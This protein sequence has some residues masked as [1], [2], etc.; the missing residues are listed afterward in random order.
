MSDPRLN[1]AVSLIPALR[2]RERLFLADTV[3]DYDAFIRMSKNDLQALIGR[4]LRIMPEALKELSE[5]TESVLELIHARDIQMV[6]YWSSSYPPLLREI[7]DAPLLLYVRGALPEPEV[8]SV[9]IVGTRKP[10]SR[11]VAAAFSLAAEL[12]LASVA[13]V[14]GLARGIDRAA[15]EG[16]R[17]AGGT[18]IAVLGS[19]VDYIYPEHH[20]DLAERILASGGGLVSEYPPGTPPLRYHF[21]ERNRIISGICRS[22]VV[23]TAPEKSGA[24]ITADYALEQGRD[25]CVHRAGL[26][27][28]ASGLTEGTLRLEETG[29][30]V[31]EHSSDL[32]ELWGWK[33][34]AV[35][36]IECSNPGEAGDFTRLTQEELED[37]MLFYNG[38]WFSTWYAV[39]KDA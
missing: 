26:Y 38:S 14:S 32:F 3:S 34:P 9:S 36:W 19:G 20:R 24:L 21:P 25:L 18:T 28:H 33:R 8:P 30:P 35:P 6:D 39:R 2:I 12:A 7:Y 4:T 27:P 29:A 23:V 5:K 17:R 22:T 13:V 37:G 11:S 15:H 31:I 1:L 16:A 10:D